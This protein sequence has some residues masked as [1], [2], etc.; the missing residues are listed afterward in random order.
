MR[1]LRST[2][3]LWPGVF[4]SMLLALGACGDDG[5]YYRPQE[6]DHPPHPLEHVSVKYEPIPGRA[7]YYGKVRLEIYLSSRGK[8]DRI[9][10]PLANVPPAYRDAAV[11]AFT[12]VG[13][14]PGIKGGR[15]VKSMLPIEV[16]YE[17]PPSAEGRAPMTPET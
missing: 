2:P 16:E 8:V 13:W 3:G 10:V 14:E 11:K 4:F 6:L 7:E 5:P 1:L 12:E 9:D 17:P 15:K